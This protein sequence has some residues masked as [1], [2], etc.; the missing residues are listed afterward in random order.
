MYL[1]QLQGFIMKDA[2][3]EGVFPLDD[4]VE[5]MSYDALNVRLAVS[6][7]SGHIRVFRVNNGSEC[8]SSLSSVVDGEDLY[9]SSVVI[10]NLEDQVGP[11]SKRGSVSWALGGE[12]ACSR[13]G[14]RIDVSILRSFCISSK[15]HHSFLR[16]CYDSK[17]SLV[18][19][20]R[21]LRGG[22]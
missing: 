10:P 12:P 5:G 3:T 19:W 4:S 14:E 17:T 15:S 20:T 11:N 9:H 13:P 1:S 8:T 2:N 21:P 16:T 22:M 6:S 7:H 18:Q